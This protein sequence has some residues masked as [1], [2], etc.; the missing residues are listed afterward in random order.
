V[1]TLLVEY[2][3][4]AQSNPP[5]KLTLLVTLT[6]SGYVVAQTN[7]RPPEE[8]APIAFPI[9]LNAFSFV[10]FPVTSLPVIPLTKIA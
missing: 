2:A 3:H 5:Y 9:D 10:P 1:G 4:D 8:L 6:D 7:T